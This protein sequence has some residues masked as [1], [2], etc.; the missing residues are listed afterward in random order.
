MPSMDNGP[1]SKAEPAP[2]PAMGNMSGGNGKNGEV[3]DPSKESF[4]GSMSENFRT[5]ATQQEVR[6]S[7]MAA[8][9]SQ[10]QGN[11]AQGREQA[12]S[13]PMAAEVSQ[14][15][16]EQAQQQ[17]QAKAPEQPTK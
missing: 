8:E 1:K 6:Q 5:D 16:G 3:P 12:R 10:G 2:T 13:S 4:S 9:A 14:V 7:Q 11:A 15:H 17:S